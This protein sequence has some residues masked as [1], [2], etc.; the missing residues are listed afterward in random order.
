MIT[1]LFLIGYQD[2]D[3]SNFKNIIGGDTLF[4]K[5]IDYFET[6]MKGKNSINLILGSSITRDSTIPDSLGNNW[7]SFTNS[8]QNIYNSFNFLKFYQDSIK[9][10]TIIVG[11]QPFD[12]P[13]SYIKNRE[14]DKPYNHDAFHIY[15]SYITNN[16]IN[17]KNKIQKI[18]SSLFPDLHI[19]ETLIKNGDFEKKRDIWTKQGFSGWIN[20]PKLNLQILYNNQS[21]N[22]RLVYKYFYNVN[23]KSNMKYFDLFNDLA[24]SLNIKVIY[25]LTPKSK[26]YHLDL[27]K[28][29]YDSIWNNILDSLELRKV[30]VWNYEKMNTDNFKFNWFSDDD[31]HSS[32][33]GAKA[34][35]KIIKN[36]LKEN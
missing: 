22:K 10:D 18:K 24:K 28:Y 31:A 14:Q 20:Q 6:F 23:K 9:I 5:K 17:S 36:R 19:V 12:F 2:F 25:V 11:I 21:K 26:Y 30:E 15:G 4:N 32:Y 8:S 29:G 35:T 27:T 33:N 7:F 34:F 16:K 3:L 1:I 13:N